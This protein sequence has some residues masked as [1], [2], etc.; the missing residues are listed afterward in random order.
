MHLKCLEIKG[1][2]SFADQTRIILKPGL[3]II[4]GPNGCGK[5]NLVDAVRWVLGETGIRGLRAQK[6]EDIIFN[7]SEKKKAQGMAWVEI[8]IDNQDNALPVEF[9][10]LSIERKAYRNAE[11]EFFINKTSVRMKDIA[12]ILVGTGLGKNS[13]SI[14][15]QGELEQILSGQPIDRR[16]VLEE[17]SG[18][19]KY[20]QQ[21]DEIVRRIAICSS[22]MIRIRDLLSELAQRNAQL[23]AKAEKA[24]VFM[25]KQSEC[26]YMEQE[27]L[28]FELKK[29]QDDYSGKKDSLEALKDEIKFI[30][31]Q[32]AVTQQQLREQETQLDNTREEYARL[33]EDKHRLEKVVNN[34]NHELAI[35]QQRVL[36]ARERIEDAEAEEKKYQAMFINLKKEIDK[37]LQLYFDELKVLEKKQQAINGLQEEILLANQQLKT[38]LKILETKKSA[39]FEM[40]QQESMLYNEYIR[41]DENLKKLKEKR[42]R[43]TLKIEQLKEGLANDRQIHS[44]QEEQLAGARKYKEVAQR[45][46]DNFKMQLQQVINTI[47]QLDRQYQQLS[48][49]EIEINNRL[50]GLVDLDKHMAGYSKGVKYIL[51][52]KQTGK[53]HG[54]IGTVGEIIK[55]PE[56][57]EKAIEVAIARRYENIVVETADNARQLIE[58]LKKQGTGR[59][60]FLPLDTL[61]VQEIPPRIERELQRKDGYLGIAS[62]LVDFEPRYKKAI[63]YLLGKTLVFTDLSRALRYCKDERY[64]YLVV[65]L[66]GDIINPSGAITGGYWQTSNHTSV[67]KRKGEERRLLQLSKQNLILKED[68]RQQAVG[69]SQQR[70]QLEDR[71]RAANNDLVQYQLSCDALNQQISIVENRIK[72]KESDYKI[73]LEQAKELDREIIQLEQRIAEIKQTNEEMKNSNAEKATEV[74]KCRDEVEVSKRE[75]EILK[76]RLKANQDQLKI[77][78]IELNRQKTNLDNFQKVLAS[79]RQSWDTAVKTKQQ[80]QNEITG[81][82]SRIEDLTRSITQKNQELAAT[83]DLGINLEKDIKLFTSKVENLKREINPLQDRLNEVEVRERNLELICLRVENHIRGLEDR[84]KETFPAKTPDLDSCVIPAYQVK[85]FKKTIELVHREIEEIGTVDL[86]SIEEYEASQERY[87]FMLNQYED[88]VKARDSL[89]ELLKRTEKIMIKEFEEFLILANQS[90]KNTFIEVFSGGEAYLKLEEEKDPFDAGVNIEV[91]LPGKRVQ[92][93]NLLSGGERALTCISFIF[94][95]LRLKPTPFCLL[96]EIDASLDEINLARFAQFIKELSKAMQFIVITHRQATIKSGDAIYGVSMP[97]QGVSSVIAIDL[98]EEKYLA[99]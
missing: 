42:Y 9:R 26:R 73:G 68:N 79:Y 37:N 48:K 23:S 40:T 70:E 55:V 30:K 87:G 74:E 5:S 28:R 29:A 91:K 83:G 86:G 27:V 59:V 16:L 49:E 50:A 58:R 61:R 2:K 47:K 77:A 85:E 88:L 8:T 57:I 18:I 67:L 6:S 12:N 97:E 22:D 17:A 92:A 1:F 33:K 11:S 32:L 53:A 45:E 82:L 35:S 96:D 24:K 25:E 72:H 10:E 3:N 98:P 21:R 69:V 19:I 52:L 56:N 89:N 13:C 75:L 65:C 14:I 51:E 39:V 63:E 15:G 54:I 31:G 7:G 66:D 84:W 71:I 64:P 44:E 81:E 43:L 93:L 60:T 34:F 20:R 90:F 99:G 95:L 46:F 76:E 36:H 80:L 4:V 78:E 41:L 62:K 94:S 38:K